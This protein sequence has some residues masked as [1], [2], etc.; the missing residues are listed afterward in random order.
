MCYSPKTRTV[1]G[2]IYGLA[3]I[4]LLLGAAAAHGQYYSSPYGGSYGSMVGGYSGSLGGSFSGATYGSGSF[5]GTGSS[6]SGG[7]FSGTSFSGGFNAQGGTFGATGGTFSGTA[8]QASPY[9]PVQVTA[10]LF[11]NR[12]LLTTSGAGFT[13]SSVGNPLMPFYG[14]PLALGLAGR[15]GAPNFYAPIYGTATTVTN[16]FGLGGSPYGSAGSSNLGSY[17]PVPGYGTATGGRRAPQYAAVIAFDHP[18]TPPS[19]LQTDLQA[20]LDRSSSLSPNRS[21]QVLVDGPVV[22]LRGTVASEHDRRL[23]ENML[24]LTPGVHEIRNELQIE[25]ILPQPR[26]LP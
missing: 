14:N 7:S 21:I 13:G 18:T 10:G 2:W 4:A 24:R 15:V 9:G 17:A 20:I 1:S 19:R 16:Q 12:N 26:P 3:G 25:Q 8:Y 5:F 11:N 6:F 22:V 23:A